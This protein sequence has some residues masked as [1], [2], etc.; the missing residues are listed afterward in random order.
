MYQRP[1][2]LL[3]ETDGGMQ[4]AGESIDQTNDKMSQGQ[5]KVQDGEK[6][7]VRSTQDAQG[8]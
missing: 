3:R 1:L 2:S 4:K 7:T 5:E 8:T 6:V